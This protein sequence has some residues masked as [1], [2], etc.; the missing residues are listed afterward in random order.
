MVLPCCCCLHISNLAVSI[1]QFL[2]KHT[3]LILTFSRSSS[4]YSCD[5]PCS[6]SLTT[7]VLPT[8]A[9]LLDMSNFTALCACLATCKV[10][11]LAGGSPSSIYMVVMVC[12]GALVFLLYFLLLFWIVLFCQIV[13]IPLRY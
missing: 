1:D 8:V 5:T 13:L 2:L 12:S 7:L 4:V 11:A 10:I 3:E 6:I 9:N